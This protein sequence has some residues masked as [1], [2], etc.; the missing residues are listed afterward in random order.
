MPLA[1]AIE[2]ITRSAYD[3][4]EDNRKARASAMMSAQ[5]FIS[6]ASRDECRAV[7]ELL[8]E[9]VASIDG[10]AGLLEDAAC[11]LAERGAS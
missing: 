3:L 5:D 11:E 10:S 1:H 9:R 2:S 7:L 4:A 6:T 8:I